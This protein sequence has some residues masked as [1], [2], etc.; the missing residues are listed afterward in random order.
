MHSIITV[1]EGTSRCERGDAMQIFH[2]LLSTGKKAWE[3]QSQ[4][5]YMKRILLNADT[6]A[7]MHL[8]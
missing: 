3:W 8:C 6:A 7:K 1:I 5:G 4:C 2:L